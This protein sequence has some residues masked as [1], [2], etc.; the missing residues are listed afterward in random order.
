[1][2]DY[3]IPPYTFTIG[4]W[5]ATNYL[6]SLSISLPMSEPGNPLIWTG[7]FS[8]SYNL[9][10]QPNG[11]TAASFD[12]WANP[13]RWRQA[14]APVVLA[15][16]G[17]Q[18]PVMRIDR[19]AYNPETNTGEGTLTQVLGLPVGDRPSSDPELEV[20][21]QSGAITQSLALVVRRLLA[22]AFA[23]PYCRI[24]VAIGA[25]SVAGSIAGKITSRNPIADANRIVGNA[26]RWL[27]VDRNEQVTECSG[28]PNVNALVFSRAAD[29]F[30]WERDLEGIEQPSDRVIVTGQYNR[31]KPPP[32]EPTP[33]NPIDQSVRPRVQ[34]TEEKQPIGK[35]DGTAN[36]AEIISERKWIFYWY[37]KDTAW[38]A[39]AT[40]FLPPSLVAIAAADPVMQDADPDAPA[41]TITVIQWPAVRIFA[42]LEGDF[43]LRIGTIEY[44][45]EYQRLQYQA[46]GVVFPET[47]ENDFSTVLAKRDILLTPPVNRFAQVAYTGEIDPIT[48]FAVRLEPIAKAEA[49]QRAPEVELEQVP[50]KGL[51][52]MAPIGWIP[53][54][55]RTQV[56]E[57]GFLPSDGAA[58]YLAQQIA[59]RE[60]RR[61]N[62]LEITM[63]LPIEY[64]AA[65]CPPLVRCSLE[66]PTTGGLASDDFC[67]DGPIIR[68][69]R[70][71]GKA[72]FSF[73]AARVSRAG[74]Q[75]ARLTV[76]YDSRINISSGVST[77][78][79]P[80]PADRQYDSRINLN[81]SLGIASIQPPTDYNSQ[82][83][84]NSG[85]SALFISPPADYD[86]RVAAEATV[87]SVLT[88]NYNSRIALDAGAPVSV[89]NCDPLWAS[90][91]LL[92]PLKG[93]FSDVLGGAVTASA[94]P[95][96]I[97]TSALDA[98]GGAGVAE[99]NGENQLFAEVPANV[100][101]GDFAI[102]FFINPTTL[103]ASTGLL[104]GYIS[105][106]VLDV[107][108]SSTS[109][110]AFNVVLRPN[111]VILVGWLNGSG[112]AS[113]YPSAANAY[114]LGAYNFVQIIR[115]GTSFKIRVNDIEVFSEAIALGNLQTNTNWCIGGFRPTGS[116]GFKG[117]VGFMHGFRATAAVRPTTIPTNVFPTSP[118]P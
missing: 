61:R 93:D 7:N 66:L 20:L 18:L 105:A 59:A 4:G 107:R 35:F 86:S 97:N 3:R 10:A 15:I 17:H 81:S 88:V 91:R 16:H 73:T 74:Q 39:E 117:L 115:Q 14:Q 13:N 21:S 48:G 82:I 22:A 106:T 85:L 2:L 100:L 116:F 62:Q 33:Q 72:D 103:L 27:W 60:S 79:V 90:V 23:L 69:D 114:A 78:D 99:F 29:T 46:A 63:P 75:I 6:D 65:G 83:D 58:Q 19:Y 110:E 57:V 47:R 108:P 113:E 76:V 1:M 89:A 11:D 64:L 80:P 38:P 31:I 104:S 26:W 49:R 8:L 52:L 112:G 95:P 12:E 56:L 87:Q 41:K 25:I 101:A 32:A 77:N 44:Q 34:R 67:V 40:P 96:V 84:V 42:D 53:T 5:D 92:M 102:E 50:V 55:A 36:E 54:I 68:L 45:S 109:S 51:A 98:F 71:N 118:C 43:S 37:P 9:S 94:T 24:P 30:E 111:G 70:Q 28:D